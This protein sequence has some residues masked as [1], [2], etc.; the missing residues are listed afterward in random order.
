M[1]INKALIIGGSSGIGLAIA[2]NL[3]DRGSKVKILA[4]HEPD[5][6]I[7]KPSE[8]EYS[9]CDLLYLDMA[10]LEALAGDEDINCLFIS[11]GIGRMADFQYFHTAEIEKIFTIDTVSAIKIIRVFYDKIL[12][13]GGGTR[14]YCGVI[15]SITGLIVS[16]SFSVYSA[17]KAGLCK[18]I[19][20]VNIELECSGSP[21]RILN[22][23]PGFIEGTKFYD[24]T[25]PNELSKTSGLAENIIQHLLKQDTLFIP[26]YKEIYKGVIENYTQTPHEFAVSSYEYKKNSGRIDNRSK[27]IIGYMSGT[28]DLFHIGHLNILRRAKAQCDYLIVGIHPDGKRKGKD[29]FIPLDERKAI[30][31]SCKYV[32]YVEDAPAEDSDAWDEWHYNKLFVGSDYKG[33][34][35]FNRYEKFFAGKDVE[36]VYFP[37]TATTSSTQ[38]RQAIEAQIV[39]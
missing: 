17:A 25:N 15:S 38:I 22:I 2:R 13:G 6:S 35:R 4:R 34:E 18:F 26:K 32:D 9:Y 8:C 20:G 10:Q 29:T 3:I 16:P 12:N 1:T 14:F 39:L 28:F 24:G 30:L 37:Y 11:A 7:I 31:A 23:A 5:T 19:E 27:I 21:N 36:I 33:S